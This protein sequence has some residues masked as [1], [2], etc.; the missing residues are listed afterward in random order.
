MSRPPLPP[1]PPP[2]PTAPSAVQAPLLAR[3][4]IG[5]LRRAQDRYG[6]VFTLAVPLGRRTVVV[7][8]PAAALRLVEGDPERAGAG[9]ARRAVLPQASPR[10]MFG[11]DGAEHQR[12][13]RRIAPPLAPEAV[14]RHQ[15]AVV[16]LTAR[17]VAGWPTGRPF[18]LLP[19]LRRLLQDCF[20]RL[21]LAIEDDARAR[22]AVD[23]MERI[24]ATP[25]NP[26]LTPPDRGQPFGR[27]VDALLRQ[28]LR[29]LRGVIADE[30]AQRRASDA[31]G[32]DVP[33]IDVLGHLLA[34]RP[35]ATPDDVVDEL[36]VVLAAAQE[37]SSIALAWTLDRIARQG[38]LAEAIAV[39]GADHPA[40]DAVLDECL[41][42]HPP[43]LGALRR[44]REP[45]DAA[46]HLLPAGTDV[47]VPISLLHRDPRAFPDPDAFRPD[48]FAG[49]D[50]RPASFL[51]FG[52]GTRRCPGAPLTAVERAAIVP[53]VLAALRLRPLSPRPERAVQRATVVVPLHGG[54]V[55]ATRR[56]APDI[57]GG[58]AAAPRP[59]AAVR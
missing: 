58:E 38:D 30:L 55:T 50:E 27:T 11:A 6:P 10:S 12:A 52:G 56:P 43:A 16:E 46:G 9:A 15:R 3:D 21:V 35:D 1:A 53:T 25:G 37:P 32:P 51:P 45:F 54:L 7:A 41:R 59:V 40:F 42:L 33:G 8:D 5:T 17:H 18:R 24:L 22:R 20:V 47:L 4:P 29:P 39:E 48:R 2:G 31:S 26:P 28:R 13:R 49:S 14:A 23:A 57:A 44:L 34:A 36:L 19:R